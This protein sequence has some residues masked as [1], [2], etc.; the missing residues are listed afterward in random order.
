[1]K[2]SV[3]IFMSITLFLLVHIHYDIM[4]IQIRLNMLNERGG[5]LQEYK[6]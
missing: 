2:W 3:A 1:M 4:S 5:I 6:P